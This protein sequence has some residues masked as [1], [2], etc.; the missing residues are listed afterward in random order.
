MVSFFFRSF[1]VCDAFTQLLF[2]SFSSG[3]VSDSLGCDGSEQLASLFGS[4][5]EI[6]KSVSSSNKTDTVSCLDCKQ[7]RIADSTVPIIL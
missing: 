3:S 6:L 2:S 1:E 7:M 4:I 5:F